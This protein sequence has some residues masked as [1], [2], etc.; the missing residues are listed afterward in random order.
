MARSARLLINALLP[1]TCAS[2]SLTWSVKRHNL[3]HREGYL[4]YVMPE[5]DSIQQ[6]DPPISSVA[7]SALPQP[8]DWDLRVVPMLW[9]FGTLTVAQGILETWLPSHLSNGIAFFIAGLVLF[10]F[11]GA[12]WARYGFG[13]WAAFLLVVSVGAAL[14]HLLLYALPTYL[15]LGVLVFI[16]GLALFRFRGP[17]WARYGFVK[18]MTF[19]LLISASVSLLYFLMAALFSKI[20]NR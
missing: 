20:I 4:S 17:R 8:D 11:R 10:R 6:P 15:S 14:L 9:F 7:E 1:T 18:W 19:C 5:A 12:R 2:G 16:G 3:A 13:K